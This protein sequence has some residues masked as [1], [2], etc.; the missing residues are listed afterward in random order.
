MP[1]GGVARL[2]RCVLGFGLLAER[3]TLSDTFDP[4][5][6]GRAVGD[7]DRPARGWFADDGGV[8][9][10]DVAQEVGVEHGPGLAGGDDLPLVEDDEAV[11]E[12]GSLIQVVQHHQHGEAAK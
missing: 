3:A 5:S 1:V 12:G 9:A 7:D 8:D 6:L 10:E 4:V 11:G 2:C